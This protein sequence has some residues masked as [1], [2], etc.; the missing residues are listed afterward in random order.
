[1]F[2]TTINGF[3][4]SYEKMIIN[5]T[6]IDNRGC[7]YIYLNVIIIESKNPK[8][9]KGDKIDQITVSSFIYFEKEDGTEY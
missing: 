3:T 9:K 7:E 6:Y 1:M 2:I 4:F 8:F 5:E